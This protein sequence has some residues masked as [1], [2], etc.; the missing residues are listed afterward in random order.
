MEDF[1]DLMPEE[2]HR[3]LIC[4]VMG[5]TQLKGSQTFPNPLYHLGYEIKIVE[6]DSLLNSRGEIVAPD[7]VLVSDRS[8]HALV[9]ECKSSKL[10]KEQ[11]DRYENVHTADLPDWGIKSPDSRQLTHDI[12]LVASYEN[13]RTVCT[14][15]NQ[16]GCSF[17]ALEVGLVAIT[18]IANDFSRR[19][20]NELFPVPIRLSYAPQ[21]LYP[22]GRDSPDHLV[23]DQV[24][25]A[26]LNRLNMNKHENFSISLEEIVTDIFPYW[27]E[28][29][30]QI[31]EKISLNI[32]R[33]VATASRTDLKSF[34]IY[35]NRKILFKVPTYWN[36]RSLQ[37]FQEAGARYV[38]KLKK[39]YVQKTIDK[40]C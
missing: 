17:P 9:V 31:K 40:W 23:M 6:W 26:L 38:N 2:K 16:W 4:C 15:L 30:T 13:G 19:E 3:F 29:G 39:E 27:N 21:Y 34:I 28:M 37:S 36:T 10:K 18:K 7:L 24:M 14:T 11:I 8:S 33:V 20:L 25:Q 22:I 1:S 5:L 35:R 12:T 32:R